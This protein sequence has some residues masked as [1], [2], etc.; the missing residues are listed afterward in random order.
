MKKIV[1][2]LLI[3][4]AHFACAQSPPIRQS[5]LTVNAGASHYRFIDES[6]ISNHLLFR[7][8]IP[9]FQL[10]YQ[11]QTGENIFTASLMGGSGK[12]KTKQG[13]IPAGFDEGQ[14]AVQ[15][16]NKMISYKLLN[17]QSEFYAGARLSSD[18]DYIS[19]EGFNTYDLLI[20]HGLYV[21]IAQTM[22]LNNSGAI[23]MSLVLPGIAFIKRHSSDGGLNALSDNDS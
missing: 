14:L 2:L 1:L 6:L 22:R 20:I 17:H 13:K 23:H 18:I 15:F 9:V 16:L 12:V 3:A 11:K 19:V 10:C 4:A 7:R 5:S 21:N 8:T